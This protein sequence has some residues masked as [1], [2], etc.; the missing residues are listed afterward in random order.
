MLKVVL[1]N[2]LLFL[3]LLLL[4]IATPAIIELAHIERKGKENSKSV[5]PN[6]AAIPWAKQHYRELGSL[7]T[8]YFDFIGWR[9]K[10]FSGTTITINDEGYRVHGDAVEKAEAWFFG[11][12]TM[13][14][15]GVNDENTIPALFERI[16]NIKS[17]NFGES[18]YT[19]HQELNLFQKL[20]V[21]GYAPK[22]VV[23]YDG[24]NDVA[25]K[26]RVELGYFSTGHERE[27]QK[28]IDDEHVYSFAY[29]FE[30]LLKKIMDAL[31]EHGERS[32]DCDSNPQKVRSIALAFYYD[33]LM[34]KKLADHVGAELVVVLQP[35]AHLGSPNL[36][37]LPKV[38]SNAILARQY[39]VVYREIIKIMQEKEVQYLNLTDIYNGKELFYVDFCHVSP[40]GNGKIAEELAKRLVHERKES[41][42]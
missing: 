11:G 31:P 19:A 17:F 22:Y 28:R 7:N 9:R 41:R 4:L 21:S 2:V 10:P 1:F 35:V 8:E 24:V 37:Y 20:L 15:T 42:Q 40:N 23:F 6:Y 27:F 14:G 13:W 18:G 5:L 26:C 34:A 12:S 25:H 39:E 16:T 33:W 38:R 36:S 32:Y 30:P 29:L 3:T